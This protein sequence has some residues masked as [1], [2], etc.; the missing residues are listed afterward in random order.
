MDHCSQAWG[1]S[2]RAS[3]TPGG[4][5][6]GNASLTPSAPASSP[7]AGP[8][9]LDTETSGPLR[10]H[11]RPGSNSL[12]GLT[13]SSVDSPVKAPP[14]PGSDSGSPT[15]E[16]RSSGRSSASSKSS[17]RRGRSLKTSQVCALFGSDTTSLH[18][19]P[20]L[21]NSGLWSDGG[22]STHDSS[23]SPSDASECSLSAV[24]QKRVSP[25]YSLSPKA[26]A[27]ILRRAAKRGRALPVPLAAALTAL[28]D[29]TRMIPT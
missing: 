17:A 8:A 24:L 9:F 5:A 1:A 25:R 19:L 29:A 22:L 2:I 28:A 4:R 6:R 16:P 27:G 26:A 21:K 20:R 13:Y 14:L 18:A 7:S 10:T 12:S 3:T 11:M 23:T 15:T